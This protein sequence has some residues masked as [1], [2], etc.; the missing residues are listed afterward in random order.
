MRQKPVP[1][2][3]PSPLSFTRAFFLPIPHLPRGVAVPIT[4]APGGPSCDSDATPSAPLL[5]LLPGP[6]LSYGWEKRAKAA[7]FRLSTWAAP[8]QSSVPEASTDAYGIASS[9][10]MAEEASDA[11][12]AIRHVRRICCSFS[13]GVGEGR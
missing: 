6:L 9:K 12:Q 1:P 5:G 11:M 8:T 3:P 2:G 7:A 4:A 13:V 10:M